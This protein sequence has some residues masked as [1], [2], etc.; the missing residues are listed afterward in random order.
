MELTATGGND[1]L[2]PTWMAVSWVLL[3]DFPWGQLVGHHENGALD[4]MNTWPDLAKSSYFL[5]I[6]KMGPLISMGLL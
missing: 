6:I 1:G 4:S 3:V 5:S 2:P